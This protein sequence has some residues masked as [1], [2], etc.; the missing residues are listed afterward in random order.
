MCVEYDESLNALKI[1]SKNYETNETLVNV[2][3]GNIGNLEK[4]NKET[5]ADY[6]AQAWGGALPAY[7]SKIGFIFSKLDLDLRKHLLTETEYQ[8]ILEKFPKL[9]HEEKT[10][11]D[12][13]NL[14]IVSAGRSAE[15]DVTTGKPISDSDPIILVDNEV[16]GWYSKLDVP[17]VDATNTLPED[18][19]EMLETVNTGLVHYTDPIQ[20][21]IWEKYGPKKDI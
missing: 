21:D 15:L 10:R 1:T 19:V 8:E 18:M 9:A 5:V 17:T 14:N 6:V 20:R 3:L 7:D 4:F 13:C 16:I 2:H 11:F 12:L